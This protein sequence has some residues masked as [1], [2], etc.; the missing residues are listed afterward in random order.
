MKLIPQA[1]GARARARVLTSSPLLLAHFGQA[2]GAMNLA[3]KVT[4]GALHMVLHTDS[5]HKGEG[6]GGHNWLVALVV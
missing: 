2:H 1:L 5:K 4:L 3:S 6:G